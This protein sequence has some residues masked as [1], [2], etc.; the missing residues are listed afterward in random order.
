MML[1]LLICPV[2]SFSGVVPGSC[3]AELVPFETVN[4][5]DA[6][7]GKVTAEVQPLLSLT[8][9]NERQMRRILSDL[10]GDIV[11]KERNRNRVT[12]IVSKDRIPFL[13]DLDVECEILNRDYRELTR[14]VRETPERGHYHSYS[15]LGSLLTGLAEDYPHIAVL[16]T[17]GWSVDGRAI[18]CMTVSDNPGSIEQEPGVRMTGNIHG[19]E[20]IAEEVPLYFLQYLLENYDIDPEVTDLVDNRRIM[21]VPM[22]NP[23]G[24]ERNS[25]YNSNGIDLNRD[26]GYMW[27]EG[28]TSPA[29]FS[30]PETQAVRTIMEPGWSVLSIDYHSGTEGVLRP[31]AYHTDATAD[32]D[33][34]VHLSSEY[35]SMAGYPIGQWWYFLYESH[36]PT[37]DFGYGS[38][39]ELCFTIELSYSYAPPENQIDQ[40][41]EDN[42]PAQMWFV[43]QAGCGIFGEVTDSV[44]EKP[45]D[46]MITIEE[47]GWPV[48]TESTT[49]F[50]GRFL[51]PGTYTV[52]VS[53]N[54]HQTKII[55]GVEVKSGE[56]T[57]LRISLERDHTHTFARQ[58]A[59][60]KVADPY[61][62]HNNHS[63]TPWAFEEPDE[64]CISIGAGGWIVFDFGEDAPIIDGAGDDFTV[65]ST[66]SSTE[67]FTA[68]V[69]DSWDGDWS[70]LGSGN[71]TTAYDLNA[72]WFEKARYVKIVDDGDGDPNDPE[73][74]YDI[75]AISVSHAHSPVLLQLIPGETSVVP[76]DSLT[77]S[78]R[79]INQTSSQQ[80]LYGGAGVLLPKGKPY[81]GNPVLGPVQFTLP[82]EQTVTRTF[83]ILVPA[84]A[85]QGEYVLVGRIQRG[86]GPAVDQDSFPFHVSTQ[87]R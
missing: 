20:Y 52:R 51:L 8:F 44:S 4:S 59:L 49:G 67:G 17:L 60:C 32:D 70:S 87:I 75:D 63:L 18:F 72:S 46:A 76:G 36:G 9:E 6:L 81:E 28:Y 53:A 45:L 55:E 84:S 1:V 68:Y 77:F 82:P 21:I 39:G 35:G 62:A 74:G 34:F 22:L 27:N 73:A 15:E 80:K 16:D 83:S 66:P 11:V 54:R 29:P 69:S 61:N 33:N 30:Q 14:W 31:W 26:Y 50:F 42:L 38:L 23:D 56:P 10:R 64:I 7:E 47:I 85:P 40:I 48:Y 3:D 86:D 19:N 79:L 78:A 25:R 65:H 58:V 57:L 5:A 41:C 24:H 71:G 37:Q 2:P 43:E 12:A 13:E